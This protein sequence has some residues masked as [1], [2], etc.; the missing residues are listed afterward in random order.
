MRAHEGV[1]IP[2]IQ[3]EVKINGTDYGIMLCGEAGLVTWPIYE[4]EP[5]ED[6]VPGEKTTWIVSRFVEKGG[7]W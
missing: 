2:V 5:P 4:G 6:L 1:A 3:T 7:V